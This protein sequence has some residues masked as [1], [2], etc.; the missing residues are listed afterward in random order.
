MSESKLIEALEAEIAQRIGV[1]EQE[2]ERKIQQLRREAEAVLKEVEAHQQALAEEEFRA[3]TLARKAQDANA[4]AGRIRR[5]QF[6]TSESL[7]RE[8][9]QELHLVRDRMDY[10][11]IWQRLYLEALDSY[12][13]E[14]SDAPVL[15]VCVRDRELAEGSVDE[16][17]S[18]E[19]D[20]TMTDGVQ[21]RSPDGRF[22]VMNTLQS[23]FQKGRREFARIIGDALSGQL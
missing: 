5:L 15:R 12:R 19:V 16:G 13:E 20:P 3:Y 22:R 18:V 6:D 23:R 7:F 11:D 4:A 17:D 21:L 8:I 2:T 1:I 14:R 9:E 10:P